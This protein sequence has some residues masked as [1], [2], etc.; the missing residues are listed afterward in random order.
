MTS[1]THEYGNTFTEV[2]GLLNILVIL[3]AYDTAV[4]RKGVMARATSSRCSLFS[5]LVSAVFALAA[6][7]GH[8]RAASAS[9]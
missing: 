7:R 6:A 5:A 4:G 2:G 3:D 8:A 9:A 1:V